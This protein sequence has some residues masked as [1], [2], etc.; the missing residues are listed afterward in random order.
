VQDVAILI[1]QGVAMNLMHPIAG[2]A[3]A[4]FV[5][6]AGAAPPSNAELKKL[7]A[8]T[9]RAFA[10]TLKTRDNAAFKNFVSDEAAC[11]SGDGVVLPGKKAVA[12][13]WKSMYDAPQAPSH[14]A[15]PGRGSGL[16]HAGLLWR[17]GLRP[18]RQGCRAI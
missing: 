13:G 2:I 11:F 3:L 10:A 14:G 9:E 8:D 15:G 4:M 18:R 1:I 6:A 5:A 7:M 17:P 16:G 12:E